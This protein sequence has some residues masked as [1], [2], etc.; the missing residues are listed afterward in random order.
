MRAKWGKPGHRPWRHQI[1]IHRD[2]L[3][4]AE[5]RGLIEKIDRTA[6]RP[7]ACPL[8]RGCARESAEVVRLVLVPRGA[9]STPTS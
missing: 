5:V 2:A 1:V 6:D 9:R 3:S 8:A 7:Q 4:G